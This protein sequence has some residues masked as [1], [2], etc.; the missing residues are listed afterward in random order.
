MNPY[1]SVIV[2]VYN[3]EGNLKT[4]Y[5]ELKKSLSIVD[6]E[7][8]ILF[9]NDG[10]TDKSEK[11]IKEILSENENVKLISFVRN[12][13]QTAAWA[14]GFDKAR[15][16]IL[17]TIDADLQNDPADIPSMW[18]LMKENKADI[19]TGWRKN[20]KDKLLRKFFSKTANGLLNSL[21]KTDIKD[22]GC[23]LRLIKK[24]AITDIHLYG[25]MHRLLPFL[26]EGYGKKII[27][28]PVSHQRRNVGKSK[29]G[30]SRTF[31]VL[32]DMLTIKL[33]TTYETKPI[34][35]FGQFGFFFIFLSVI[36]GLWTIIRKIFLGG[37][38]LS[39]LLFITTTFFTVGILCI[40]MGLLAE[41]QMRAWYEG[42]GKKS[43]ILK[44]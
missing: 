39:P 30:L 25:E 42:T 41:I 26:L 36:T 37:E 31:K 11:E 12:Y 17:I 34:Y 32:L 28:T 18:E 13:G 16:E 23:S 7:W 24:S 21:M 35:L 15:G 29:Y 22:S 38:W 2:P 10:S 27:Q 14:A 1:F 9:V 40:L 43:Y 20:R 3:E 6:K 44:K 33:L 8:E 19:V 5:N 4:L